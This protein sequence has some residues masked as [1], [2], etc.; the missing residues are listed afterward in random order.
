MIPFMCAAYY[1]L[2]EKKKFDLLKVNVKNLKSEEEVEQ[3]VNI[4]LLLIEKKEEGTNRIKLEGMFKNFQKTLLADR[5][6]MLI[7]KEFNDETSRADDTQEKSMTWF[8]LLKFILEHAVSKYNKSTKLRILFAYIHHVKM[9]NKFKALF[10][11]MEATELKPNYLEEFSIFRFMMLIEEDMIEI[12]LRNNNE[13]ATLDVNQIVSFEKN[14]V[15]F[16]I[17]IEKAVRL[18][19]EFWTELTEDNPNIEKLETLGSNIIRTVEE[20][21][22]LFEVLNEINPNH[23]KCLDLFGR[24]LKD[25]SNDD[26]N[27][28]RIIE[29]AEKLQKTSG[30]RQIIEDQIIKFEENSDLCIITISGNHREIGTITNSNTQVFNIL[31]YHKADLI[32]EKIETIMP[33]IFADNHDH[34]LLNYFDNPSKPLNIE[35]QVYPLN[36]KGYVIPSNLMAKIV[37]NLANGIQIVGFLKPI[38]NFKPNEDNF[39]LY[40]MESGILYGVSKSCYRNFG[41]RSSLT[42]G[43]CYT[44]SELNLENLCPEVLDSGNLEKLKSNQGMVVQLDTT[45]ILLNHPLAHEFDESDD[46]EK[47]VE[48]EDVEVRNEQ[49]KSKR[50]KKYKIRVKIVED[51]TWFDGK[52]TVA[53]LRFSLVKKDDL[54]ESESELNLEQQIEDQEMQ[55][56]NEKIAEDPNVAEIEVQLEVRFV[57]SRMPTQVSTRWALLS[58]QVRVPTET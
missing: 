12:D 31:G 24:F 57:S 15:K 38:D 30:V 14:F 52:L 50:Y 58:I 51:N 26:T 43:K 28:Q 37:P 55:N 53:V 45:S 7:I 54:N 3:F 25:I 29:R 41:I 40:S 27:G 49:D 8:K 20:A 46:E 21:K 32:G 4:L 10:E 11:L 19:Y 22:R 13:A 42:F 16:N 48:K 36:K 47:L 9:K 17:N 33:K 2:A 35:R 18:H 23:Y 39:V 1:F 44:M 5:V 6:D 56:K 34:L